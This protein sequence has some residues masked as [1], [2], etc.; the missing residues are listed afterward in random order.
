MEQVGKKLWAGTAKGFYRIDTA[1][2][3]W[4]LLPAG[5]RL[6]NTL[7]TDFHQDSTG[8]WLSSFGAGL[9][10]Y[11]HPT[12]S[13]DIYQEGLDN[14]NLW[15]IYPDGKGYLWLSSDGGV[16]RFDLK[17]RRF[18]SFT[19][20]SDGLNF[21][22]FSMV[23]HTRDA[24]G[25]LYFGNPEG[26]SILRPEQLQPEPFDYPPV[27]SDLR[28]DY[29][30]APSL[31]AQGMK[32]GELR[33][34]PGWTNLDL[35]FSGMQFRPSKL[36]WAFR[37]QGEEWISM[38][39][40]RLSVGRP[41][42]GTY[43]LE[44]RSI[45]RHGFSGEP[46]RLH[47]VV[48]PAYYETWWFR[49]LLGLL[50]VLGSALSIYAYNRRQYLRRIRALETQQRVAQERERI[51]RDL[52]DHVG[53]HLSRIASDL[54]LMELQLRAKDAE[55][56]FDQLLETRSFTTETIRLLRDTIWAIDQGDY[57]LTD[58][59]IKLRSF[60]EQYLA[61][62]LPWRLEVEAAG[63][64]ILSSREVL[65]LLRIIQEATQNML[66]YAQASQFSIKITGDYPLELE[67]KDNGI[68]ISEIRSAAESYGMKNMHERAAEIGASF[69]L[70][71]EGGVR[72]RIK[73]P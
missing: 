21:N 41:E 66:K 22:D 35:V 63:E 54:D 52:H 71:S 28:L 5:P 60:L 50:L 8:L 27:L 62:Y 14:P 11:H 36:K 4:E 55:G 42:P 23:A 17:K 59:S 33:L 37:W 2:L 65:N 30:A 61:D 69:E 32:Q 47:L 34:V 45:N 72:I 51:S 39:E 7:I 57:S 20:E 48:K 24:G 44:V 53:A 49:V 26:I 38:E 6:P 64:R 43:T 58:F 73:L 3:A 29:R 67:V 1:T 19:A 16:M 15:S 46:L 70:Q 40:A 68:G 31:L 12:D 13:F 18:L 56:D 9:Y 10:L 25:R